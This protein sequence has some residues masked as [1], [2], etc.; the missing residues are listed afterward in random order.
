MKHLESK[1]QRT[2]IQ[3]AKLHEGTYPS[4]RMLVAIPNG[5]NRSAITGAIL[6]AEGVRA[7][8]PDLF[9]FAAYGE[10]HG[11]AI[12]MKSTRGV[13]RPNQL[14]WKLALE[15]QGYAH[16]VCRGW[17]EASEVLISYLQ[18]GRLPL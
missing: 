14:A 12:E 4:L 13:V 11:L 17:V 2:L 18:R 9:L 3:W 15:C 5:G 1:E 10:H 6:K 7:G 8:F 16:A